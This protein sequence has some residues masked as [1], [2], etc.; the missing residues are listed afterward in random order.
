MPLLAQ[1]R[2]PAVPAELAVLRQPKREARL[3]PVSPFACRMFRREELQRRRSVRRA[4]HAQAWLTKFWCD[5]IGAQLPYA[6]RL[7]VSRAVRAPY[8]FPGPVGLLAA[9]EAVLAAPS[10]LL[11]SAQLEVKVSATAE[12]KEVLPT[13][14]ALVSE[15]LLSSSQNSAAPARAL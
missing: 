14:L 4:R 12:L 3:H 9:L 11:C 5:E 7:T 15:A 1:F 6:S 10:Q 8:S 13:G 2:F